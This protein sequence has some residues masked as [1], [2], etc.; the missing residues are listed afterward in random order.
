MFI[1]DVLFTS[2]VAWTLSG[3]WEKVKPKVKISVERCGCNS[4][5]SSRGNYSI[6]LVATG[7]L[8]VINIMLTSMF[9]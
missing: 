5:H 3:C 6:I 9:S 8:V 4:A 7:C 1:D 2:T